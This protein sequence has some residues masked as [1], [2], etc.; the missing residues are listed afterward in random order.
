MRYTLR[1][2]TLK[3]GLVTRPD[4]PERIRFSKQLTLIIYL[5]LRPRARATREELLG[6]LW[7]GATEHDARSS[8]R[9]VLYQ[10]RQATDPDLVVG[11]EVLLLRR[12]DVDFDVDLFRVHHAQGRLEEALQLYEADF[13]SNVAQA[14]AG[15]FEEWAEG[16]RQQLSAE[17]RQVLRTLIARMADQAR[18]SEGAQYAQ[19]LI[20][21][22]PGVLEPRVKLV[23]LLA[24]SGDAIRAAGAAADARAFVESIEGNRLSPEVEHAIALALAPVVPV[25]REAVEPLTRLPEMV[26]RAAEFRVLVDKWRSA[27]EGRGKAA[28]LTGEAGI[29]K[30]RLTRELMG[31]LRRDRG[32]GLRSACYAVEQSDPMAPFVDLL[33]SAPRAPGLGG[34]SPSC[35]SILGAFVPEIADRF[36]SAVAP[37]ALPVDPQS[38]GTALLEAFAAIA[39]EV[40]LL[41]VVEDLHWASPEGIEFAH[42]LA[43][44]AQSHH[45]LLLLTAR[46]YGDVPGAT[47]SLRA[48]TASGAVREVPLGPLDLPEVEQ[49]LSSIAELPDPASGRWLA[50]ELLQ[51]TQGVPLY[52]LEILKS[53]HDSGLLAER[54]GRW[55]FGPGLS[56]GG[57]LPIPES[58][59]AILE[60]RLQTVGDRPA[61]VLAAMAVWGRAARTD[62]LARLTGLDGHEVD[63]AIAALERRRL[64]VREDGLPTVAHEA[65]SAAALRSAPGAVLEHL[66]ERAA[67]LA[68]DAAR[69]GRAGDW[70]AAARYAA[71]AGRAEHAAMDL[72]HAAAAVERSSGRAAGQDTL[73][74]ALGTMPI[75]VRAHLEIALQRVLEGRWS[76]RRWLAEH[77][78][79]PRRFRIAG[80]VAGAVLLLAAAL[81]VPR[82][83]RSRPHPPPLGG[84]Y[85]V[86]RWGGRPGGGARVLGLRVDSQFVAESLPSE[87]LPPGVR[88]G[89]PES[90]VRPGGREVLTTCALPEVDPTAVCAVDLATGKRR[91]LFRYDGDAASL[92]WLPDGGEFL[93][94]GGYR[95]ARNGYAYAILLVDSAGGITR[96]VVRDSFNYHV[97]AVSPDGG[98]FLALRSLGPR[99]EMVLMGT[100][101]SVRAAPWC[102][103]APEDAWSPDGAMIACA[104]PG[105]RSLTL[106]FAGSPDVFT[107]LPLN[108]PPASAPAW[109][110]DSRYLAIAM[111]RP[112][113][114]I[115][116]VD[117]S[118]RKAP[119]LVWAL[120]EPNPTVSWVPQQSRPRVVRV[121]VRPDSLA[122]RAG[123]R[124]ALAAY[125]VDDSGRVVQ[126]L[127]GVRW[128]NC[129]AEIVRVTAA[130][131]LVA[132][133]PGRARIIAALGLLESDTSYVTV[134]PEEPVRLLHETFD[135]GL[136][137]RL[138]QPYGFPPPLVIPHAGRRG[139]AG[140]NNDG[141]YSHASGVALRR[142]LSLVNG[143]TVEYWAKVPIRYPLWETVDVAFSSGP[144]DSFAVRRGDPYPPGSYPVIAAR[145]PNPDDANVQMQASLFAD[146]RSSSGDLPLALRDGRWHR[147]RLAVYPSGEARWFA[148]GKEIV[149]PAEADINA[150]PAWTLTLG[151]QSYRTLAMMDDVT[152]WQGVVLDP[153]EPA[154]P[155]H[156]RMS[157]GRVQE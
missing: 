101:G 46:D 147:Y 48:L 12:E 105:Q 122:V 6:L 58:A 66:H 137:R 55:V 31:R 63:R 64:V 143:L 53:L 125:G 8:L 27:L 93:A 110:P 45:V 35:L 72:A 2:L 49:L 38:L 89:Y 57:D 87:A 76:A 78:A 82:V 139:S 79:W 134:P 56:E 68:R 51:R 11:D 84:G 149:P 120:E 141:D 69:G 144:P 102:R 13:L 112:T 119:T 111:N 20:E 24:L 23:E 148:D 121:V 130:G 133:R 71:L 142:P 15:E 104:G 135:Q 106:A 43:R 14:G 103:D 129:D 138:W 39:E 62:V 42:R 113:P 115:Y 156:R 116:V 92:G 98:E 28:L 5:A 32:L 7:G 30:T 1:T 17:R 124:F 150:Q 136:D 10:I 83:L 140:F 127:P 40:P 52:I 152:V 132:D 65:L 54:G 80:A 73:T 25:A 86:V 60:S 94:S 26:G 114:G 109:S 99:R 18:W 157:R 29:G 126:P 74:R 16:L 9:Q 128:V 91:P 47:E 4:E 118:G 146:M 151:G 22:D 61:A 3:P 21:A 96:T 97:T 19:L 131:A 90:D 153:V 33:R 100:D 95:S 34:A 145:A 37:S 108:Y 123:H 117:A 44:R 59:A 67:H 77:T 50:R 88:D 107:V 154:A 41:L 36:R 75:E 85:L 81:Y 155:A 70:M